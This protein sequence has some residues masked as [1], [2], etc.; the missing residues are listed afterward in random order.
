MILNPTLGTATLGKT[1]GADAD[2]YSNEKL[3]DFK[4]EKA[5]ESGE[6]NLYQCLGYAALNS[7]IH[8]RVTNKVIVI[9]LLHN[10]IETCEISPWANESRMAFLD[11]I[12]DKEENK[13]VKDTRDKKKRKRI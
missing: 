3:V 4:C 5:W 7:V 1:F 11:H 8:K 12:K 2:L 9:N 6:Y 13:E 10:K